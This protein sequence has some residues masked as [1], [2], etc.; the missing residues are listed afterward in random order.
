M[1]KEPLSTGTWASVQ[2]LTACFLSTWAKNAVLGPLQ[3]G[4]TAGPSQ[5]RQLDSMPRIQEAPVPPSRGRLRP[6]ITPCQRAA[7]LPDA[8]RPKK[9]KG[10]R[11][12]GPQPA[13]GTATDSREDP[14]PEPQDRAGD[15]GSQSPGL[16][17]GSGWLGFL[18]AKV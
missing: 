15:R 16:D 6:V 5:A 9:L 7:V 10:G 1:A 12:D 17:H 14:A 3:Q 13:A 11:E 18:F 2:P 8:V 4:R